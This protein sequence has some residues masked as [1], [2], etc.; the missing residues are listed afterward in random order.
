MGDE[1]QIWKFGFFLAIL[2]L[3]PVQRGSQNG[4]LFA[5]SV[6]ELFFFLLSFISLLYLPQYSPS[7]FDIPLPPGRA[8][9]IGFF[10][11]GEKKGRGNWEQSLR[12]SSREFN[13]TLETEERSRPMAAGGRQIPDCKT[14]S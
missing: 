7:K 2:P 9:T 6:T 4:S 8:R 5:F 14:T 12:P 10:Q 13:E 11:G 3:E 1:S